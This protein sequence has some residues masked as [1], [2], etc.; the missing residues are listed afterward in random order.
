MKRKIVFTSRDPGAAGQ[1]LPIIE[2][3]KKDDWLI[4]YVVASGAA[5]KFFTSAGHHCIPFEEEVASGYDQNDYPVQPANARVRGLVDQAR[6]FLNTLDPVIL[7]TGQS[8]MGFG[9]DEIFMYVAR[10]FKP[11]ITTFTFFDFWGGFNS[12]GGTHAHH[13]LVMDEFAA[14]LTAPGR[15]CQIHV[16][17]SPKHEVSSRVNVAEI[18]RQG[19]IDLG[20]DHETLAI[21]FFAQTSK[22]AGYVD[23]FA[24][25]I[26]ALSDMKRKNFKFFI[27]A[28]P[29]EIVETDKL[30]EYARSKG[31]AALVFADPADNLKLMAA[32]DIIILCTSLICLDHAYL[33]SSA[34]TPIGCVL[35]LAVGEEIKAYMRENYGF[36]RNPLVQMGVGYVAETATDL[37]RQLADIGSNSEM[38]DKYFKESQKLKGG[39]AVRNVVNLLY[40]YASGESVWPN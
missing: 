26:A 12:L 10:T 24:C 23:N 22:I 1:L 2:Q 31:V 8:S 16:V 36:V 27:K 3:V 32:S 28:H 20:L 29:K 13:L 6:G 38:I 17:G 33:S 40:Q 7:V 35:Y 34:A 15:Q 30:L 9:V 37:E 21:S 18:R 39:K 19:R 4:P 25:L 14:K 11:H 5:L